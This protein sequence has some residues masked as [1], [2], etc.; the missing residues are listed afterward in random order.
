M[1]RVEISRKE[2]ERRKDFQERNNIVCILSIYTNVSVVLPAI[3]DL[4]DDSL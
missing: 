3:G 1:Q 2:E 4:W